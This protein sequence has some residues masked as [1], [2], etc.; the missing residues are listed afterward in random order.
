MRKIYFYTFSILFL[1]LAACSETPVATVE[2]EENLQSLAI[3]EAVCHYQ[4]GADSWK[5]LLIG[6]KAAEAHKNHGDVMPGSPVP[7]QE[8]YIFNGNC[9]P[10][11]VCPCWNGLAGLKDIVQNQFTDPAISY[12]LY[13]YPNG[14][15]EAGIY[16]NGSQGP[17]DKDNFVEASHN[18]NSGN[19]QT[20][21]GNRLTIDEFNFSTEAANS[22]ISDITQLGEKLNLPLE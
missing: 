1:F 14:N 20:F 7:E 4:K 8:G 17:G 15:V 12:G 18:A 3:K 13:S 2:F 10:I 22:C 11:V 9:E 19:C 16:D 6:S 5:L 21:I